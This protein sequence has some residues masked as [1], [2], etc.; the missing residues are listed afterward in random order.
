M[1][2]L[3]IL[4]QCIRKYPIQQQFFLLFCHYHASSKNGCLYHYLSAIRSNIFR[5]GPYRQ[6]TLQILFLFVFFYRSCFFP[7]LPWL[8]ANQAMMCVS[9]PPW[10]TEVVQ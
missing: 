6:Q 8:Q 4:C 5:C 2:T 9:N 1:N 10:A 7:M 3:L